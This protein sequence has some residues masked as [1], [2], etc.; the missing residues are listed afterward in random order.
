MP[1]PDT[2]RALLVASAPILAESTFD[3]QPHDGVVSVQSA[4]YANFRGCLAA[5]HLDET[6]ILADDSSSIDTVALCRGI[7]NELAA[8]V[9]TP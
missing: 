7:A 9:T 6:G 8:P 1:E 5:D 4:R 3:R 2:L